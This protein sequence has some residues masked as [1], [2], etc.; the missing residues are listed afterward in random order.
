M[1]SGSGEDNEG[2]RAKGREVSSLSLSIPAH[3][4]ISLLTCRIINN[5]SVSAYVP[6]VFSAPYTMSKHAILGLTKCLA[7]DGR[8]DN[9]ACSQLD[10]GKLILHWRT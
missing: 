4:V 6:R 3:L 7:L 8:A 1:R 9:I 2:P 5:G 10:I